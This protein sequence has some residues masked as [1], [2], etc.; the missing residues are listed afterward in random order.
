M[1]YEIL[2]RFSFDGRSNRNNFYNSHFFQTE[3]P[4]T[5]P[6]WA[7]ALSNL[8]AIRRTLTL[9]SVQF[10]DTRLTEKWNNDHSPASGEFKTYGWNVAGSRPIVGTEAFR[11]NCV[12]LNRVGNTGR[13]GRLQLRGGLLET[14]LVRNADGSPG[15][16]ATAGSNMSALLASYIPNYMAFP[17]QGMWVVPRPRSKQ[18]LAARPVSSVTIGGVAQHQRSNQKSSIQSAR[19]QLAQRE[20]NALGT[21]I[22]RAQRQNPN[23]ANLRDVLQLLWDLRDAVWFVVNGLPLVMRGAITIPRVLLSL[24]ARV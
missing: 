15:L 5:A 6:D 1:I 18:N 7:N 3:I 17:V 19:A 12:K 9:T 2:E 16:A 21:K 24:P 10:M 20:V 8:M 22:V 4:L 14:D 13:L 23:W 11:V